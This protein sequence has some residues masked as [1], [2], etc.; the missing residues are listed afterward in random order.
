MYWEAFRVVTLGAVSKQIDEWN[1]WCVIPVAKMGRVVGRPVSVRKMY[2]VGKGFKDMFMVAYLNLVKGVT[3]EKL[4]M[5]FVKIVKDVKQIEPYCWRWFSLD[6][7]P[8]ER[9]SDKKYP[10]VETEG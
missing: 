9:I 5:N 2:W 6:R 7:N 3:L 8:V 4:F 1:K 10:M